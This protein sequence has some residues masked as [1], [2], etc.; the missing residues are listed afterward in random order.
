[1]F[2]FAALAESPVY[3]KEGANTFGGRIAVQYNTTQFVDLVYQPHESKLTID[4]S[5]GRDVLI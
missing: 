3:P 4:R 2:M 5:I 1:M